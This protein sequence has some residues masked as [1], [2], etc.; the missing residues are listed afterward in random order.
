[1]KKFLDWFIGNKNV[2][3]AL[4]GATIGLTIA[5]LGV[6]AIRDPIHAI[7]SLLF[8]AIGWY[9]NSSIRRL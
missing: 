9:L 1:M 2:S 6:V 3:I 7:Q 4:I 5:S 8:L